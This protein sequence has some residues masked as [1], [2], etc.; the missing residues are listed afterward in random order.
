MAGVAKRLHL[1]S[2]PN[3]LVC[4]R[5]IEKQSLLGPQQRIRNVKSAWSV[6]SDFDIHAIHVIIVDDTMTTGATANEAARVLKRAGCRTGLVGRCWPSY[7]HVA[8]R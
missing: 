1:P 4:R 2:A 7:K 5:R 6:N 8:Y 3:L